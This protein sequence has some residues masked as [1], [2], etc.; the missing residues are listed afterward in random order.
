MGSNRKRGLG[1]HVLVGN[2]ESLYMNP[3]RVTPGPLS[4]SFQ[5]QV[6]RREAVRAEVC[7]AVGLRRGKSSCWDAVQPGLSHHRA[8]QGATQAATKAEGDHAATAALGS[9]RNSCD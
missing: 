3:S 1:F 5:R 9:L 2:Q 8:C 6:R 7:W 4:L